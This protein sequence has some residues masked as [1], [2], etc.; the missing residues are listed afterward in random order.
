VFQL[1]PNS[2]GTWTEN[3]IYQSGGQPIGTMAIDS[4][5]NLYGTTFFGGAYSVGTVYKLTNSNGVW[6]GTTIYDFTP[7][8]ETYPN[9]TGLVADSA[10]NL[11]GTTENGGDYSVGNV[12]KLSPTKGYWNYSVVHTFT[13]GGDGGAPSGGLTIDQTGNLYG[14][15]NFGGLFQYGTVYKLAPESNGNWRESVLHSFTNG[16]DGSNPYGVIVDALGNVYGTA[17]QGGPRSYGVAYEIM[18]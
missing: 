6:T 17:Q 4:A 3:L 2:D 16:I 9:P 5:G 15:T 12:Y 18:P 11:Y 1:T 7:S 14:T 8:Y 13:G 10:G